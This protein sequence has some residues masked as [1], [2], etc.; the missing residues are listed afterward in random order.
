MEAAVPAEVVA[1]A[2]PVSLQPALA[3]F[4]PVNLEYDGSGRSW[5]L[6]WPT[7]GSGDFNSLAGTA[8]F[9]ELP[10]GPATHERGMS[11]PLYRW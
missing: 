9:L 1:L 6:P 3:T 5:A 2:S 11:A 7:R 8:G 10:P 4:L